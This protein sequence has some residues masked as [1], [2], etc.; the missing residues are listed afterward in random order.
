[1]KKT[2]MASPVTQHAW[3]VILAAG[4][5]T[6]LAAVTAAV[7]GTAIPKQFAAI[8]GDRT[9]IQRTIDRVACLIPPERTVV[10]V[11]AAREELARAQLAGFDGIEIV[12]QPANRG[13]GAGVLLPLA[14]VLARDP[15]AEVVILP[16][17]HFV[18]RPEAF[19][20]AIARAW[21]V[22]AKAPA[23]VA[24]VGAAAESAA[25]DLGWM[26]GAALAGGGGARVV[27]RF[28]EKPNDATALGLLAEGALWNTL[29]VAG[30]AQAL[31]Q[32]GK[33]HVPAV[34]AA[35]ARYRRFIGKP[36][37][38]AVLRD[39]YAALPA[40][41]I[42][43]DLLQAAQGLGMVA[44]IDAGWSDCG[45]PERLAR[46]LRD[47]LPAAAQAQPARRHDTTDAPAALSA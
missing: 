45:T 40:S 21:R 46:A 35:L 13:T 31:W 29:I 34:T 28:V 33:K 32:L 23:R 20:G 14:H 27:R 24:L 7:H 6:R 47:A 25:T 4:E 1:M 2:R 12:V 39:I 42:S 16:S 22:A 36:G 37:A 5:G 44:M 3:A 26:V 17:D 30:K 18:E 11:A 15:E 41:D 43:R 10:V 38:A 9:F 19:R 8:C